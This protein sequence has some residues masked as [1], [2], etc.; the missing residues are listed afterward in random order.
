M[1]GMVVAT[2]N[3]FSGGE[4]HKIRVGNDGVIYCD[5][6]EW[7][8]KRDCKHLEYYR[9]QIMPGGQQKKPAEY[10]DMELIINSIVNE[11][12]R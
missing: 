5:C 12:K 3:S 8:K 4:S 2:V 11:I 6:W 10:D 9:S 7:K 1:A